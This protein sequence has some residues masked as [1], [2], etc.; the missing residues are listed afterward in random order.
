MTSTANNDDAYE[1][2]IVVSSNELDDIT[3]RQL[4]AAP[5][6]GNI[7]YEPVDTYQSLNSPQISPGYEVPDCQQHQHWPDTV[8]K[9]QQLIMWWAVTVVSQAVRTAHVLCD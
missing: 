6:N 8:L 9:Y 5:E 2:P 7:D 3:Q 4:P 1:Q